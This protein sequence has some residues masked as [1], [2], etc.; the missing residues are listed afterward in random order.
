MHSQIT[1]EKG[2]TEADTH[3][4]ADRQEEESDNDDEPVQQES[5]PAPDAPD[6]VEFASVVGFAHPHVGCSPEDP[7]EEGIEQRTHEREQF[8]E[9]RDHLGDDEG[10][11]PQESEDAGPG[12][13]ADD[14]VVALVR[15]VLEDAE[16]HES[17][18]DTGV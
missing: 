1:S 18:G 7:A 6:L 15:R 8:R 14:R 2:E 10:H 5:S 13:P 16:E 9:E 12:G 4:S 3:I 17:G 11:Q